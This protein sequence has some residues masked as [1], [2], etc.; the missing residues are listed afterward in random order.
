VTA[1][2]AVVLSNLAYLIGA[3]VLAIVGVFIVWLRY[4]Q[5][6]S[7]HA[8]VKS[9]HRGLQA[10]APDPKH[11]GPGRTPALGGLRIQPKQMDEPGET[12]SDEVDSGGR[13]AGRANGHGPVGAPDDPPEV[14][15]FAPGAP[16]AGEGGPASR[17]LRP[18]FPE[19]AL[20]ERGI[21]GRA[22]A[23]TG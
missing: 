23:E 19:R 4:R 1:S 20:P 8:N 17:R 11:S 5:P 15:G 21:E 22:G 16:A 14:N 13:L 12:A 6:T 7:V 10:L 3:A 9:F 18:D 2:S